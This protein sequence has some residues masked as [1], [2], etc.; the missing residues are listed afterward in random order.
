[1][2]ENKDWAVE[3]LAKMAAQEP[4]FVNQSILKATQAL[5]A[6]QTKRLDQAQQEVDGRIWSP[7]K[8]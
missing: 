1:M 3:Q 5:I 8:W 6:E 2:S 4:S 7:D